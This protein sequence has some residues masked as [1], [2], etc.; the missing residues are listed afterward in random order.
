VPQ[1]RAE[2][3]H[4]L[5]DRVVAARSGRRHQGR[6]ASGTYLSGTVGPALIHPGHVMLRGRSS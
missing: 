3:G 6:Y 2:F 1:H 5:A 4:D